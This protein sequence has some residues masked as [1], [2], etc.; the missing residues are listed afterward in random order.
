MKNYLLVLAG[1]FFGGIST[2]AQQKYYVG[3]MYKDSY[4]SAYIKEKS[5]MNYNCQSELRNDALYIKNNSNEAVE[6]EISYKCVEIDCSG[7]YFGEKMR[8]KTVKMEANGDESISGYLHE[9]RYSGSYY[10]ESF[11]IINVKGQKGSSTSNSNSSYGT[12]QTQTQPEIPQQIQS[13]PQ[14]LHVVILYNYLY[15]FPEDLGNFPSIPNNVITAVNNNVSYGYNDWRVPTIEEIAL[16][17]ANRGNISSFGTGEYMTYDG[18]HSGILRLVRTGK[19]LESSNTEVAK[20]MNL[21]TNANAYIDTPKIAYVD[22]QA[23]LQLMPKAT[24]TQTN[25][26]KQKI[27]D[28]IKIVGDEN[29]FLYIFNV[30]FLLFTD[31]IDATPLVKQKLGI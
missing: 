29:N 8:Y 7:S 5:P 13:L 17:K 24:E 28:A 12:L 3:N 22:I 1:L 31:G 11:S 26:S 4:I 18:Q 10:V 23:I 30:S 6:V 20:E 14:G 27:Q 25:L 16:M 19:T 2:N 9:S 15:V 21:N